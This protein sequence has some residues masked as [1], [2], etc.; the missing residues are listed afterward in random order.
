MSERK[1]NIGT[2]LLSFGGLII[3]LEIFGF[4]TGTFV[5]PEYLY[6]LGGVFEGI[7]V[8]FVLSGFAIRGNHVRNTEMM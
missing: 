5:G 8:V 4:L 3:L 7:G 1:R 2:I 6:F